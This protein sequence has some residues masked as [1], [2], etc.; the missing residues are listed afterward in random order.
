M[1]N[2]RYGSMAGC[3]SQVPTNI[4]TY[5]SAI[6]RYDQSRRSLFQEI[7]SDLESLEKSNN[8]LNSNLLAYIDEIKKYKSKIQNLIY[9]IA[10]PKKGLMNSF[11]CQFLKSNFRRMHDSICVKFLTPVFQMTVLVSVCAFCVLL[12][13]LMTFL[14]G[15]KSGKE[16]NFKMKLRK[17][18][19]IPL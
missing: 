9:E 18:K 1:V 16:F 13:S 10:D 11:N 17:T 8:L 12:G 6:K 14:L 15:W 2:D 3:S 5:F 4:K 19:V 7:C